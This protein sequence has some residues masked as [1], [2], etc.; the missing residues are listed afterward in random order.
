[1]DTPAGEKKQSNNNITI[2]EA[3]IVQ[4]EMAE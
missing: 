2:L 1:M 3:Y 4:K